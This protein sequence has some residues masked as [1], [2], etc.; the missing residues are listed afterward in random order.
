MILSIITIYNYIRNSNIENIL[1]HTKIEIYIF[2]SCTSR[3]NN[4]DEDIERENNT[5]CS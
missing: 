4:R 2:E 1:F 3:I 5:Y